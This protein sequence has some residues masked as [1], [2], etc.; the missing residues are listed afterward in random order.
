VGAEV[1]ED[2]VARYL[3]LANTSSSK[4]SFAIYKA[5]HPAARSAFT[6]K[7]KSCGVI[8]KPDHLPDLRLGSPEEYLDCFR[9]RFDQAVR[10]RLRTRGGIG[11]QLSGGL[12]SGAVAA[13]AAG[14]LGGR[15]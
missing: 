6:V 10:A 9:E 7:R 13:T 14:L 4:P 12:D 2:Y 11:A 3:M 1:D 8:G 15:L 5:C